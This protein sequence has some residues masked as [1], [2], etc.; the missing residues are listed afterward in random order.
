MIYKVLS[1]C[2][3]IIYIFSFTS[4]CILFAW[5]SMFMLIKMKNDSIF[6]ALYGAPFPPCFTHVW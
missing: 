3:C 5:G 6:F 4:C 1:V 2:A